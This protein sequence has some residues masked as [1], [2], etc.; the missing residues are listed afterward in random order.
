[1]TRGE[2]RTLVR[3]KIGEPIARFFQN[4]ELDSWIND[5][6]DDIAFRTNVLGLQT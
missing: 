4:L 2:I 1:M 3:T 6:G 5:A